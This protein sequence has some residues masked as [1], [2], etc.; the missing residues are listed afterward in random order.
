MKRVIETSPLRLATRLT[1][2]QD[3]SN[4]Q[5]RLEQKLYYHMYAL[6]KKNKHLVKPRKKDRDADNINRI[7]KAE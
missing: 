7:W 3:R 2:Y 4:P 6:S 1:V 5:I